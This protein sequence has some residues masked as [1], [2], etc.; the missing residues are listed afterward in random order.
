MYGLAAVEPAVYAISWLHFTYQFEQSVPHL[1][2]ISRLTAQFADEI[3]TLARQDQANY[4]E[5]L[6]CRKRTATIEN[7]VNFPQKLTKERERLLITVG[8]LTPVKAADLLAGIIPEALE[9]CKHIGDG[10]LLGNGD[11]RELLETVR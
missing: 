5:E 7:P 3:V 1:R 10:A 11:Y 9:Q 6:H 8:S 4:G 2:P